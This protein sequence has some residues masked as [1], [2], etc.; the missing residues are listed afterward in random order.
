MKLLSLA[1]TGMSMHVW[2]HS[3]THIRTSFLSVCWHHMYTRPFKF[4]FSEGFTWVCIEVS[5]GTSSVAFGCMQMVWGC[6]AWL[7]IWWTFLIGALGYPRCF[8]LT[9]VKQ[10]CKRAED[11]DLSVEGWIRSVGAQPT[12]Q[13]YRLPQLKSRLM[14]SECTLSLT[15]D[16]LTGN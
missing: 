4:S 2:E 8:C 11:K 10:L 6:L 14:H 9:V 7:F 1:Q 16:D 5:L 12:A 13:S 15:A 3:H